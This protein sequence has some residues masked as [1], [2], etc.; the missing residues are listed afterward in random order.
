MAE[1]VE[2]AEEQDDIMH[3]GVIHI[4]VLY[5]LYLPG[6]FDSVE[7]EFVLFAQ[8]AHRVVHRKQFYCL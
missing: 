1:L 5:V 6:F 8:D 7:K 3:H 2:V 4:I